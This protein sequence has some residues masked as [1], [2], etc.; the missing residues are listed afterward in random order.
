MGHTCHVWFVNIPNASSRYNLGSGP[1]IIRSSEPIVLNHYHRIL[2]M[3]AGKEG[4]MQ[5]DDGQR[6]VGVSPGKLESL[7]IK[8]DIFLGYVPDANDE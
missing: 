1:V 6:A 7:N 8:T 4:F 5:L 2:A 3:R